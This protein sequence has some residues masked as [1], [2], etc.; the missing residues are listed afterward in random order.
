MKI[1]KILKII[2]IIIL[3]LIVL[4]LVHT[5]RNFIIIRKLQSNISE[6]KNKTNYHMSIVSHEHDGIIMTTDYYKKDDK[7]A[8][9]IERNMNGDISK[10]S[11]YNIAGKKDMFTQRDEE[12]VAKLDTDSILK[13]QDD[14]I[15]N[16][17]A[18]IILAV[19]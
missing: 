5:L 18:N 2:G 1:K 6:Y 9:L 10:I 15:W 7:E 16:K 4:I 13:V 3:V 14:W 19:K 17:V 11:L 12:K 8:F